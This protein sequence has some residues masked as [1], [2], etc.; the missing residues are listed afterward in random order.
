M[1]LEE[2]IITYKRNKIEDSRG[3]FLKVINGTEYNLPKSTGEVYLTM[4]MPGEMKGSHYHLVANEWFT[5]ITGECILKLE[6]IK[7]KEYKEFFLKSNDPISIYVPSGIAHAFLNTSK[8]SDFILI[9]Y[10]DQLFNPNDTVPFV[11]K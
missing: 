3:W 8:N 10:S 5:L 6:D 1:S 2:K 9:A 7:T 4:A 11:F